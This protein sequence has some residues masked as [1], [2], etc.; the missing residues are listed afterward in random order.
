MTF[1][2]AR[3][4]GGELFP[5][6]LVEFDEWFSTEEACEA[7]VMALRWPGGFRCARCGSARAWRR[8]RRVMVC[9]DCRVEVPLT[10]GTIFHKT[11]KPLRLWFKAMWWLTSQ[12]YGANALGLQRV[13]GI[14]SYETAWLWLHKL[15]HAMVRPGRDRL[16]DLVEVDETYVGGLGEGVRGRQTESK[17]I[18]A[19]A[20]E[21]RGKSAIGRI[22]LGRIPDVST[23]SLESFVQGAV[24]DGSTIVTDGWTGYA[25]LERLGYDHTI[26]VIRGSGQRADQLLPRPHRIASLLKRWLLGTYQG[27]A[28]PRHL[29]YYL[30]EFTFRFNRR[31]STHRG[32][33]FHRLMQQAVALEPSTYREIVGGRW[34]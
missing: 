14:G 8:A 9:A 29:D 5:R 11:R 22:R 13:L 23:A 3:N 21:V 25:G 20:A 16:T 17:A 33:L 18:V 34:A 28:S 6:N 32:K 26:K 30:D 4:F 2:S 1:V 10:A 27:A 7:Y 15:R 12:K 31:T 24:E 19:I